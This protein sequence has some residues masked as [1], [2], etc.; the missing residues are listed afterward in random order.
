MGKSLVLCHHQVTLHQG[1][2]LPSLWSV[3]PS[4]W[5]EGIT[6][7]PSRSWCPHSLRPI[8]TD[9]FTL[10]LITAQKVPIHQILPNFFSLN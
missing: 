3:S 2:Q 5:A 10:Q 9:P 7:S 6:T 8:Y 4:S 1:H